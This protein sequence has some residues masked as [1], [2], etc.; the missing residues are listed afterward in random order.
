MLK[1][2]YGIIQVWVRGDRDFKQCIIDEA[3]TLGMVQQDYL[4]KALDIGMKAMATPL[5]FEHCGKQDDQSG[6]DE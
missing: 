3:K 5:F 6:S 1:D 4:R 2:Q